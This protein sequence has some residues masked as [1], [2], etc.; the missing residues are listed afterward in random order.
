M[1]FKWVELPFGCI[2][3]GS[4]VLNVTFSCCVKVLNVLLLK[5]LV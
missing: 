1:L 2:V 3:P 4:C 5:N